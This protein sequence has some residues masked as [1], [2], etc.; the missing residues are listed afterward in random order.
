M[1]E[2]ER[3]QDMGETGGKYNTGKNRDIEMNG[4]SGQSTHKTALMTV[5]YVGSLAFPHCLH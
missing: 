2:E 1:K 4:L 5:L 3:A